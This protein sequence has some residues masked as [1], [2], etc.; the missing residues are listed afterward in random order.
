MRRSLRGG[1]RRIVEHLFAGPDTSSS[2]FERDVRARM[3]V[4]GADDEGARNDP[5]HLPAQQME[6]LPAVVRVAHQDVVVLRR[7]SKK[8]S[9][10]PTN[11]R[12]PSPEA[13]RQQHD[14]ARV[15]PHCLRRP[16]RNWSIIICAPLKKSPNCA[17]QMVRT[18]LLSPSSRTR[19]RAP[20][21]PRARIVDTRTGTGCARGSTT[22]RI[23][24]LSN[25]PLSSA[26]VRTCPG[27]VLAGEPTEIAWSSSVPK[28]IASP[29]AQSISPDFHI[30]S[31]CSEL[32]Q[33]LGV[34][35]EPSGPS[36][37]RRTPGRACP[38]DRSQRVRQNP[39]GAVAVLP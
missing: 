23:S 10:R 19:T 34:H 13:V 28:A 24:P 16:R 20:R 15:W 18:S 26:D 22:V 12:A 35:G 2:I 5:H 11:A 4:R 25:R 7:G 38:V 17:S 6:V 30:T 8:R 39:P 14:E 37:A 31:R 36:R 21:T 9:I 27:G 29:S 32:P 1:L 3:S 33:E